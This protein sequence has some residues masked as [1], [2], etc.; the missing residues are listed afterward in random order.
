MNFDQMIAGRKGCPFVFRGDKKGLCN[1]DII[2]F[3]GQDFAFLDGA[4]AFF[5]T[6]DVIAQDWAIFSSKELAESHIKVR[7]EKEKEDKNLP[8]RD[9]YPSARLTRLEQEIASVYSFVRAMENRLGR[10]EQKMEQAIIRQ[11]IPV[12]LNKSQQEKR[13]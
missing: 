6:E 4:K 11:D 1:A 5:S 13:E 10:I 3:D 12:D 8:S 7:Q 2:M 9:Y